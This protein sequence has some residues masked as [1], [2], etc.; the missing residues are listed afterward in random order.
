MYHANCSLFLKVGDKKI[1]AGTTV[2]W[3]NA[4]EIWTKFCSWPLY[5]IYDS[6]LSFSALELYVFFSWEWPSRNPQEQ[7]V[8]FQWSWTVINAASC[9]N[10]VTFFPVSE[11]SSLYASHIQHDSWRR[12]TS[13]RKT[14]LPVCAIL[15]IYR[16]ELSLQHCTSLSFTSAVRPFLPFC[17]SSIHT[18][19]HTHGFFA[20]L[21]GQISVK[22]E[23][24]RT[25]GVPAGSSLDQIS[26]VSNTT[27]LAAGQSC[28]WMLTCKLSQAVYDVLLTQVRARTNTSAYLHIHATVRKIQVRI[29]CE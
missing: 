10:E 8:Q 3:K 5:I 1:D 6:R 11:R 9:E 27:W 18:H 13:H 25:H 14:K 23:L 20:V 15:F 4:K 19:T 17:F 26:I 12:L 2:C 22:K 16:S 29:G 21:R 24:H 7:F 28:G